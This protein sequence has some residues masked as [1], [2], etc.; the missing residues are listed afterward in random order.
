[1]GLR[2]KQRKQTH[3][4]SRN[5]EGDN[6]KLLVVL[7]DRRLCMQDAV[8]ELVGACQWESKRIL[9][10]SRFFSTGALV[11]LYKAHVLSFI[12]YKTPGLYHA[13]AGVLEQVDRIQ[14]GFL[15]EMGL[16]EVDALMQYN[17][18][19]LWSRRDMAMLGVIHRAAVGKGPLQLR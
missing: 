9:T 16:S 17:L 15:R 5:P 7:F 13:T 11:K 4:S 19:P 3:L 2:R 18:A 8:T 12:E 6:F 14:E 10:A 1:M